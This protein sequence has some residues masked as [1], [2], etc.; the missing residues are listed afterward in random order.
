MVTRTGPA[1]SAG[2]A[3][4]AVPAGRAGAGLTTPGGRR[5]AGL[6]LGLLLAFT[7]IP[8]YWMVSSAFK[9]DDEIAA[10]VPTLYP[11]HPTLTQFRTVLADGGLVRSLGFSAVIAVLAT[12]VVV[13]LGAGAAFAVTHLGFRRSRGF[14]VGILFTQLLPQSAVLVPVYLLWNALGLTGTA[15]GLGLV[16]LA[17]YLPV[18]VW[19][20]TGFFRSI[21]VELTE[22][23]RI[24]GASSLRI[25]RSIVL[26][27]A[28]P[29]LAATAIYTALSCW[30]EFLLALVLLTSRTNTVTVWLAGLIG[31]HGTDLG[32]LMAAATIATVPPVV[33]F[34]A[35]Q[36]YFVAGLT[37]GS[38]KG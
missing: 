10:L 22:A 7:L 19:M 24:D 29:A 25:L 28:R 1:A 16:Y 21:P 38:V 6:V 4:P 26:P 33:G 8:I 35:L 17:L 27:V 2:S 14:L 23:G 20:L 15:T 36:R 30:S 13:V 18:A 32:Q 5:W 11:H 31:E 12:V 34:F 3:A 37:M 9:T